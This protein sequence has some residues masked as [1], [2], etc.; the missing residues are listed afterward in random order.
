[1]ELY[2]YVFGILTCLYFVLGGYFYTHRREDAPYREAF[3]WAM[4]VGGGVVCLTESV[5]YFLGVKPGTEYIASFICLDTVMIPFYILEI[6]CIIYQDL[7]TFPWK[8]RWMIVACLDFPIVVLTVLSVFVSGAWIY[9]ASV[10]VMLLYCVSTLVSGVFGYIKY[11]RT[12]HK[13]NPINNQRI[14]WLFYIL[15]LILVQIIVYLITDSIIGPTFYLVISILII[16]QHAFYLNKQVPVNTKKMYAEEQEKTMSELREITATLK[17]QND[18][19]ALIKAFSVS[20]PGFEVR[21]RNSTESKLTKH[22]IFLCMLI[23][24]GKKSQEISEL[25]EITPT[26]VEVARYRLRSKLNVEK[27]ANLKDIISALIDST[28]RQ[29][30]F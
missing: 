9:W 25:L 7:Q 18:I 6:N 27:G 1:M 23:Y 29:S 22:D 26:S 11:N 17:K 16:L 12:L 30:S 13:I 28:H 14:D 24:E 15:G 5:C 19:D 4:F 8:R 20:H 3:A 2:I 10:S 21:L